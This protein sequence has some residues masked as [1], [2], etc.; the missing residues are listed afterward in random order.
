MKNCK[1][2]KESEDKKKEE[3]SDAISDEDFSKYRNAL[4]Y[5]AV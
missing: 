2:G 4:C 5:S 1:Y 3:A